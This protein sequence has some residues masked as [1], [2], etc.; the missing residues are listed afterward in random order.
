MYVRL[1]TGCT[2]PYECSSTELATPC[3]SVHHTIYCLKVLTAKVALSAH[4]C[5]VCLTTCRTARC[6]YPMHLTVIY[7]HIMLVDSTA[8]PQVQALP[9]VPVTPPTTIATPTVAPDLLE[10]IAHAKTTVK[11]LNREFA[12]NATV[13]GQLADCCYPI[14][15]IGQHLQ[16]KDNEI[17]DIERDYRRSEEQ[18]VAMLKKWHRKFTHKATYLALVQA[19]VNCGRNSQAAEV[20][21]IFVE[22]GK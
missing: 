5:R 20:C 10:I 2:L 6:I 16:L 18:R 19:L 15:I 17:D 1:L 13:L 9:P 11:S 4:P 12:P 14:S 22:S 8:S 21:K 7:S 3:Q